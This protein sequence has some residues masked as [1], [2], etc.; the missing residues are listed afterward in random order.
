MQ[1]LEAFLWHPYCAAYQRGTGD[2]RMNDTMIYPLIPN[3]Y[4]VAPPRESSNIPPGLD[5]PELVR[6][7]AHIMHFDIRVVNHLV[8]CKNSHDMYLVD[9]IL[10]SGSEIILLCIEY[11]PNGP[12]YRETTMMEYMLH[13][14]SVCHVTMGLTP[15]AYILTISGTRTPSCQSRAV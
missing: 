11:E 4:I 12:M 8:I 9:Y 13:I 10:E 6:N 3:L 14:K 15:R 1:Q 5:I 7:W 2:F